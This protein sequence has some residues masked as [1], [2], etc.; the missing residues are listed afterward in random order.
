MI[1][2]LSNHWKWTISPEKTS[3]WKGYFGTCVDSYCMLEPTC[4]R[5]TTAHSCLFQ[6]QVQAMVTQVAQGAT[7]KWTFHSQD[8]IC[9]Y[10]SLWNH[11]Q[12]EGHMQRSKFSAWR[13]SGWLN[14]FIGLR[15]LRLSFTDTSSASTATSRYCFEASYPRAYWVVIRKCCRF[16]WLLTWLGYHPEFTSHAIESINM[17]EIHQGHLTNLKGKP[18]AGLSRCGVGCTWS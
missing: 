5:S 9:Q 15:S 2:S 7:D 16:L 8:I 10:R 11:T 6:R 3:A 12:R 18:M 4:E 1:M 13:S 14:Q 17:N